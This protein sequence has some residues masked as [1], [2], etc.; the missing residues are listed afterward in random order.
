V[1]IVAVECDCDL[2]DALALLQARSFVDS[3]PVAT[4]AARIV[5]GTL[6]L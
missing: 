6:R 4:I 1:G 3:L 5:A 2:D